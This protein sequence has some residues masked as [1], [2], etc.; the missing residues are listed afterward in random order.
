MPVLGRTRKEVLIEFRS[1]ELLEAAR[2]VFGEKGFH[3]ATVDDIA[4]AAGVA[5]GT[6]YLYYP[7]KHAVYWAALRHG[8]VALLEELDRSM[9]RESTVEAKIRAYIR[10]KMLYFEKHRDFF[11]IYFSEFGHALS[12]P[13]EV[14]KDF[15]DLY[16]RQTKLL[17]PVVAEG[18][19]RKVLRDVPPKVTAEAIADVTRGAITRRLVGSSRGDIQQD[20]DFIFG[21]VWK[22]MGKR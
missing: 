14:G 18:V 10:T 9:S 6:L 5:K 15:H 1:T 21:L 17:S 8:I 19:R 2:R 3:G 16:L 11:R 13:A 12:H 7:S 4:E 20:I 22:G